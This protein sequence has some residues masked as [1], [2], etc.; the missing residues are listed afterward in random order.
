MT[1]RRAQGMSIE[2]LVKVVI[3]VFVIVFVI[4]GL[5][6]FFSGKL[7]FFGYLPSFN[8]TKPGVAGPE[9][10]R[11]KI[12]DDKLQYY[13]S[14]KWNDLKEGSVFYLNDKQLN[15]QSVYS[16]FFDYF[17]LSRELQPETDKFQYT[18]RGFPIIYKDSRWIPDYF[19]KFYFSENFQKVF[20]SR[21]TV[22]LFYELDKSVYAVDLNNN[23]QQINED[24]S[25]FKDS[26]DLN[27]MAVR[28]GAV[29]WR[30]SI[31]TKPI[32]IGFVSESGQPDN[33]KV[34]M[35]MERYNTDKDLVV[36]LANPAA[37]EVCA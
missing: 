6:L 1:S 37:G 13:D 7:S 19:E 32:E 10:I 14:T 4:V 36:D 25:G 20:I 3:V 11:Y 33:V 27:P 2:N 26:I 21:G 12:A 15:Y 18:L 17:Y 8:D 29:N 34:C 9:I 30:D 22:L 5:W 31:F 16:A 28:E 35:N 23:V 24:F